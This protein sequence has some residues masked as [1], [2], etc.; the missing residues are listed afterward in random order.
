MKK[1][2]EYET[3]DGARFADEA[4]ASKHEGLL[5][6]LAPVADYKKALCEKYDLPQRTMTGRGNVIEHYLHWRVTG[7]LL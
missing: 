2:T 6:Q 5:K 3:D 4:L 1:V 7:E